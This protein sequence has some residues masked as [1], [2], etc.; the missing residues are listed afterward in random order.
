MG[1]LGLPSNKGEDIRKNKEEKG[2]EGVQGWTRW[3]AETSQYSDFPPANATDST[4]PLEASTPNRF[5]AVPS[6]SQ[7][8]IMCSIFEKLK[9][10]HDGKGR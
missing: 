2:K 6:T 5:A 3:E 7:E 4:V 1:Q 10:E 9:Q 8:P